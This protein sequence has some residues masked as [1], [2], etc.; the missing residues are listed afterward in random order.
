MNAL[1]FVSK[2]LLSSID[3]ISILFFF[4]HEKSMVQALGTIILVGW[5]IPLSFIPAV[6]AALGMIYIRHRYARSSRDLKRLTGITRSPIYSHLNSSISGL[7]VI[8]SYRA[9]HQTTQE[10]FSHINNHTKAEYLFHTTIRWASFRFDWIS[11]GFITVVTFLGIYMRI[12]YQHITPANI[13]LILAYSSN[14]VD[15][16]QWSIRYLF[17]SIFFQRL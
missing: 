8:R 9:E 6:L 2:S 10:M 5:I 4:S 15:L 14:L 7:K 17:S 1:M 16:I 11:A 3:L 13:A 12:F